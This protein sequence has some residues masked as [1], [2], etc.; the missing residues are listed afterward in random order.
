MT[1]LS[2]IDIKYFL[3]AFAVGLLLCYV[4]TPPPQVVVKFPSPY[5]AGKVMY[6]DGHDT[7]FMYKADQV[8]CPRDRA[9]IRPQPIS[10]NFIS[11]R[12]LRSVDVA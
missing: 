9:M 4:F 1:L 8:S 11:T 2:K 12:K 10:E 6:R 7:C 3:M 5:N